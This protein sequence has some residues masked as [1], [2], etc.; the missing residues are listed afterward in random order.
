MCL[1]PL[2]FDYLGGGLIL[3]VA[4]ASCLFA[5]CVRSPTASFGGLGL[6][7]V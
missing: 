6:C 4:V 3:V 1:W 5:G 2:S 7:M